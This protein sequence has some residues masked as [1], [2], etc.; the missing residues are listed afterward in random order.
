MGEKFCEAWVPN[1]SI[2]YEEVTILR[3]KVR[4]FDESHTSVLLPV[5]PSTPQSPPTLLL[6][7]FNVLL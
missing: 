6:L 4:T 1:L 2:L 5:I 7:I 3:F